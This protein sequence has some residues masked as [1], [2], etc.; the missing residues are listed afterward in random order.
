MIKGFKNRPY[1]SNG[2]ACFSVNDR[3]NCRRSY[4]FNWGLGR[5]GRFLIPAAND[6]EDQNH[7]NDKHKKTS[8]DPCLRWEGCPG[9]LW[10][11]LWL[12]GFLYPF[13]SILQLL[14]NLLLFFA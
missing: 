8:R 2:R 12:L 11:R 6:E 14:K 5:C 10:S 7:R 13:S 1:L 9:R 3:C 4:R